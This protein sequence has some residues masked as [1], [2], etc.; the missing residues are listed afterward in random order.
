[1]VSFRC[2]GG[3]GWQDWVLDG[4]CLAKI[5]IMPFIYGSGARL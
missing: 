2:L 5:V 4:R 3:L 1:M